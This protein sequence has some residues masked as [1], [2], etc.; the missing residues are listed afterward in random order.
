VKLKYQENNILIIAGDHNLNL[1]NTMGRNEIQGLY[2]SMP[3]RLSYKVVPYTDLK[4]KVNKGDQLSL[5]INSRLVE[6][7]D[8]KADG[9][10][11][12]KNIE[13]RA[14]YLNKIEILKINAAG[15]EEKKIRY[16]AGSSDILRPQTREIELMAGRYRDDSYSG[17]DWEGYFG[18]FRS[19]YAVT[20]NVSAY[21]E[22]A[23]YN[24]DLSTNSSFEDEVLSSITGLALRV[25]DRVVINLDW[26]IAGQFDNLESGAQAELLYSFLKG[27]IRGLYLYIPPTTAEY[28]EKDE[29]EDKSI[30]LRLDLTDSISISPRVGQ[31]NTL[32]DRLDE[33]D[34][35]I[36]RIIHNPNW[37]NY[38]SIFVSYE[39]NRED[40]YFRDQNNQIYTFI[41]NEI[42]KGIGLENNI[43]GSTFRTSSN[44]AYYDNDLTISNFIQDNYQDYEAEIDVYKRFGSYF[45]ISLSYDGEQ[46]RDDNGLRYYDRT[47]D[48]QL[49][50]SFAER[51]SLTLGSKRKKEESEERIEEED[52]LRLNYYFNREFSLTGELKD[53]H[54]E[55]L[56][57]Y[58]SLS[59]S[60]NYYFADNPGYIRLY[61][62][63]IVPENGE[64]GTS[65]GAIYDI[66]RDDESEIKIEA[67]REYSDF[68]N[69]KYE[70]FAA[71]SYSHAISFIGNQQHQTRFTDFEPRPI[72]AGYA[73]LDQNYNGQMD[74]GEKR[75]AD[76]PMR[77][78]SMMTVSDQTGF[79]IFKPY[80]NDLYLLNFDYRNLIADY[81]PVTES[82]L[83]RV[84]DNQNVSQNF[85]VTINGTVSG[86]VFIDKNADGDK[87]DN[88]DYLMWAGIELEGL[89]KKDYTNQ[90]GEF[91]F[92]NVP[93]GYHPL[94]VLKDS[95]PTGTR[96]LKGYKQ[97]IFITEDQLDHHNIDIPIVYGD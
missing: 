79:F 58:Q 31:K 16:L 64:A 28:M 5:F 55:F 75:L 11:T 26:L 53:Y 43:Y 94:L 30:T 65:F 21:L 93:L 74:E 83:V 36:F 49:R 38:N 95:L 18:A 84:K 61:A 41:G 69:N 35:Y 23:V 14:S 66:V 47:Y 62:E 24:Q 29:G 90:R 51:A 15:E 72:V 1:V 57:D 8:I 73:Y 77:L 91:Y 70:D 45:L 6:K 68:I 25:S 63:Y 80:F 97:N 40:Y 37:R 82:I 81:T 34:Y 59:L 22:T 87:D 33:T 20:E 89:N 48:G 44:L 88:E 4:I 54:S 2:F 46:Q 71:I 76:I 9:E 85:G 10:Y 56:E 60:G 86:R 92:Q 19:S 50:L 3:D 32:G 52:F 27:Y 78:G 67:R 42:R 17:E 13:L 12:F 39:E 96:P 7:E